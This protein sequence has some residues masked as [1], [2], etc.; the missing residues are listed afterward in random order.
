MFFADINLKEKFIWRTQPPSFKL[1]IDDF[2]IVTRNISSI[3]V[4]RQNKKH[5]N[6][7][8]I[9]YIG[10]NHPRKC[11]EYIFQR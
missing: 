5:V 11:F 2:E 9:D 3:A 8:K 7:L 1:Y 10:F 6:I 4:S